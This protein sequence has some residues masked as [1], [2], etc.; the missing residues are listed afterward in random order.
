MR[1][2]YFCRDTECGN[3]AQA[4]FLIKIGTTCCKWMLEGWPS[5]PQSPAVK[6]T[7]LFLVPAAPPNNIR[8]TSTFLFR[9]SSLLIDLPPARFYCLLFLLTPWIPLAGGIPPSFNVSAIFVASCCVCQYL[10]W[11]P[12]KGMVRWVSESHLVYGAFACQSSG[13][14]PPHC[15]PRWFWSRIADPVISCRSGGVIWHEAEQPAHKGLPGMDK[16]LARLLDM[17]IF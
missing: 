1:G 5:E 11:K 15:L 6:M 14:K 16:G 8:L 3:T 12:F 9:S 2:F 17:Y 10:P 4:Y 7:Q 13:A